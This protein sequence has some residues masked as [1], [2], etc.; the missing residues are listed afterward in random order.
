M[1]VLTVTSRI[2]YTGL[3]ADIVKNAGQHEAEGEGDNRALCQASVKTVHYFGSLILVTLGGR[4]EYAVINI[5]LHLYDKVLITVTATCEYEVALLTV[6]LGGDTA[7]V[8]K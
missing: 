7:H 1:V 6:K 4:G 3:P 5:T 8:S 2:P